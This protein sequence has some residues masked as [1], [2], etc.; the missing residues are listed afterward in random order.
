MGDDN[1]PH[2]VNERARRALKPQPSVTI[3]AAAALAG[4]QILTLRRWAGKGELGVE[5]RGDMDVV[6][7][8]EVESLA[9]R[10]RRTD[11]REGLRMRLREANGPEPEQGGDIADLQ[12]LARERTGAAVR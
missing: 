11:R 1:Y 7:L 6:R 12:L 4:V 3:E 2:Y 5:R 9:S 8:D 10:Y